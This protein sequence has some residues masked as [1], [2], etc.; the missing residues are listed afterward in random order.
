MAQAVAETIATATKYSC[1]YRIAAFINAIK[2]I[3]VSSSS[4]PVIQRTI[5]FDQVHGH[6]FVNLLSNVGISTTSFLRIRH[7][8][9]RCALQVTYRDAGLTMA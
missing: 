4:V 9:T 3:E 5:H 2:K 8:H 7:P 6:V 1:S